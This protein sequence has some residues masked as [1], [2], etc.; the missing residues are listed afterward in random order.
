MK[1]NLTK[2]SLALLSAVFILGCQ[3]Q[4][5]SPVEPAGLGPQFGH[6]PKHKDKSTGTQVPVD[7]IVTGGMD[8]STPGGSPPQ[9]APQLMQVEEDDAQ[10]VMTARAPRPTKEPY[11]NL[12]IT[13]T[14]TYDEG[15]GACFLAHTHGDPDDP[16]DLAWA[17][18]NLFPRLV[19]ESDPRTIW[20][21]IDKNGLN[22][23]SPDH[24]I[25]LPRDA[26]RVIDSPTVTVMSDDGTINGNFTAEF[27]RGSVLVAGS[28]TG[29]VRDHLRLSCPIHVD[30]AI[31]FTVVRP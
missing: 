3:D 2:V 28:P 26:M 12:A 27:T 6:Q 31:T 24:E 19:Q 4:G 8:S 17:E 23:G 14:N 13:M 10:L 21:W 11:F 22:G 9:P 18:A 16:E 15:F 29:K 1:S 25:S 7:V 20:V 30:D 5:S